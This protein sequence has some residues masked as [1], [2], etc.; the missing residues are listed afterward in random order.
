VFSPSRCNRFNQACG[1]QQTISLAV[2]RRGSQALAETCVFRQ[3]F[4][5]IGR[6]AENDL[7]LADDRVGFR[8]IY[9]QLHGGHWMFVNLAAVSGAATSNRGPASGWFDVGCELDVGPYAIECLAQDPPLPAVTAES[10]TGMNLPAFELELINGRS[11]RRGRRSQQITEPLTLIGAARHC[12]LWLRDDG[13]SKVHA[14]LVLTA[15]GVWVIDLLGRD[16]I[17]V[18]DLPVYWK[19]LHHGSVLQIGRFRFRVHFGAG[20]DTPTRRAV[21]AGMPEIVAQPGNTTSRQ[22]TTGPAP[23][24]RGSLSEESMI[25]LFERMGQMQSEFLEHS[26]LQMQVIAQLLAHLGRSQQ[27]A[28]RQDLDRIDEISRELKAIKSEIPQPPGQK[29]APPDNEEDEDGEEVA[30][31][32]RHSHMIAKS[33]RRSQPRRQLQ[34]A[35]CQSSS[36][37]RLPTRIPSVQIKSRHHRRWPNRRPPRIWNRQT[38]RL[39]NQP[40]ATC[41]LTRPRRVRHWFPAKRSHYG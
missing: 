23:S 35:H 12:N 15:H 37:S 8:H 21:I 33:T 36:R 13:V 4:V 7:V 26:Q 5:L 41:F 28:V 11:A 25:A 38:G 39:W 16:G 20:R 17:L 14:S 6:G 24:S 18:D 40:R 30:P 9:L 1:G 34:R 10:A 3:P 32:E 22:T 2:A 31:A 27:A 29:I 19:Q